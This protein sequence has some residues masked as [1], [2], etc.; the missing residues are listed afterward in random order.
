[1]AVENLKIEDLNFNR[2]SHSEACGYH[3]WHGRR[4]S[5]YKMVELYKTKVGTYTPEEWRTLAMQ[6]IKENNQRELYLA[7]YDHCK[8]NCA[9]LHKDD[10]IS[11]YA[12]DCISSHAY[13]AWK[14]FAIPS[15][16]K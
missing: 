1:M 3:M 8:T 5:D 7:V 15:K 10:Q 13:E 9:W 11:E 2:I 6:T 16:N 14:D 12:L 4:V